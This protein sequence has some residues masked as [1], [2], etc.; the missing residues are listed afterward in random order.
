ME[1][2]DV[3]DSKSGPGDRV[4]VRP[5]PPAPRRRGLCIV[6]DGFSFEKSSAHSRRRSSFSAKSPAA[7]ALLACKRARNAPACYQLFA[8]SSLFQNFS[9][10]S[11]SLPL[12]RLSLDAICVPGSVFY[13]AFS[14]AFV[15]GLFFATWFH[16]GAKPALHRR[17]FMPT[18]KGRHP[19]ASARALYTCAP[20][21]N[22][23][24]FPWLR[25][26]FFFLCPISKKA[27]SRH[28]SR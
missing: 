26:H 11:F 1:L 4:R 28:S 23:Y 2:A 3:P 10:T 20:D 27:G 8:G 15:T 18:G 21:K 25:S 6:R 22:S 19:Y 13:F 5:P 12:Y 24:G 16:A 9:P 14:L 7:P 17:L